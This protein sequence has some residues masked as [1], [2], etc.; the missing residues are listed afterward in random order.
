MIVDPKI[1]IIWNFIDLLIFKD[2]DFSDESGEE[3][4]KFILLLLG[5]AIQGNKKKAFIERITKLDGPLQK[6][7]ADHIQRVSMQGFC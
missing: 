2:V 6:G 4:N 7:I 1:S 5:C 3:V